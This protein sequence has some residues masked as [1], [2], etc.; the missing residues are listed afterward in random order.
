MAVCEICGEEV[1]PGDVVYFRESDTV[2]TF[3]SQEHRQA[4]IEALQ[5]AN[6]RKS[7]RK[8]EAAAKKSAQ[9]PSDPPRPP[10]KRQA[11]KS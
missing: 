2:K 11:R 3:C 6:R 5:E 8:A 9:P 4:G 10:R 7:V 1:A